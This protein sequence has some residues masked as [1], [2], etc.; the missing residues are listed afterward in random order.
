MKVKLRNL[1]E[2]YSHCSKDYINKI[3]NRLDACDSSGLF[4]Y[5]DWESVQR[6]IDRAMM[7]QLEEVVKQ[8]PYN[9]RMEDLDYNHKHGWIEGKYVDRNLTLDVTIHIGKDGYWL[10]GGYNILKV[11]N[12]SETRFSVKEIESTQD[13]LTEV[14]NQVLDKFNR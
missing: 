12:D 7:R 6:V 11:E 10:S 14:I 13:T 4:D 2:N 5:F 3:M 8:M 1:N 9:A